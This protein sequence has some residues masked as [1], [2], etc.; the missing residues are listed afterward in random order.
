MFQSNATCFLESF[1]PVY[2][3]TKIVHV[4]FETLNFRQQTI[5]RTLLDQFRFLLTVF[6]D[7]YLV[8]V[9]CRN[10]AGF[11]KLTDSMLIN[12]GCYV[13]VVSLYLFSFSLPLWNRYKSTEM[14]EVFQTLTDCDE[15]LKVLGVNVD[16]RKHL[17]MNSVALG[18]VGLLILTILGVG[19]YIRFTVYWKHFEPILP[20]NTSTL[21]V[22]RTFI[23]LHFFVCYC[24]LILWSIR[25]RFVGLEQAI[26]KLST[27]GD[28]Q[29]LIQITAKIHDQL[30]DA[31][32]LFNRCY[33][34]HIMFLMVAAFT[35]SIFCVFGLIH[36]Y[37]SS[38][39]AITIRVSWNNM[40]YDLGYLQI[41]LQP[42]VL[43]AL[44]YRASN[45]VSISLNKDVCY[46]PYRNR[47][48]EQLRVLSMQLYHRE[49]K[50]SCGVIDIDWVLLYTLA[51]SFTT[52][53]VILLQFD[54]AN[55]ENL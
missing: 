25:E 46:R 36:S 29:T 42:I 55:F 7:G 20:D 50:I 12:T 41:M 22:L 45:R 18:M 19:G 9:G 52:Y 49:A 51:G 39:N 27:S 21:S 37:A 26:V 43:S 24:S 2:L 23:N 4:H 44:V 5:G 8:F 28:A 34:G 31:V 33:S 30:C 38:A 53:L 14:F 6:L 32:Q 3:V 47:T 11:L 35:Y 1:R 15:H 16:H 17:I 40:I 54:L 13:S 48:F 10:S